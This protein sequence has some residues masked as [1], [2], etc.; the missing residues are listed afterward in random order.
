MT[1]AEITEQIV[2]M[3]D[4]TISGLAVFFSM[5]SAYIVALFFFIHRAPI[6]LK[7]VA[8]VFFTLAVGFLLVFMRGTF[9]HSD[10]LLAAL[11]DLDKAGTLGPVGKAALARGVGPQSVDA[12]IQNVMLGGLAL[13]YLAL[14]YLTFFRRWN[15]D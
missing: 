2:M 14:I 3:M 10:A 6:V 9:D 5:I 8:F 1:E 12:M 4:M 13:V 11:A 15:N 7:L